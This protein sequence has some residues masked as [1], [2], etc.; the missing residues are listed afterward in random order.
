MQL[1]VTIARL[2]WLRKNAF[3]FEGRLSAPVEVIRLAKD[4][5]A[6]FENIN[7]ARG[8][9]QLVREPISNWQKPL[10]GFHKLNWNASLDGEHKLMGI[11]IVVRDHEGSVLAAMC[12]TKDYITDPG[13]AKA[14]AAWH[15]VELS[16]R[17]GLV[18]VMLEGNALRVINVFN[19]EEQWMGSYGACHTRR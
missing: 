14:L 6:T 15:V 5:I 18:R 3:V 4:H 11:G 9:R 12:S 2:L 8:K 16:M 1:F 7:V 13:N 10:V 19:Q 17:L